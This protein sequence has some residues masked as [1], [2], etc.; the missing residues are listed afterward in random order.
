MGQVRVSKT[1]LLNIEEIA[2]VMGSL[3][4]IPVDKVDAM[5]RLLDEAPDEALQMIVD[6]RIP[7]VWAPAKRR[8]DARA[9]K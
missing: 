4:T 6:R 8:L 2:K 5:L 9:K 7:F 1:T 3:E